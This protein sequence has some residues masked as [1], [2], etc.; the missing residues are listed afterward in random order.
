MSLLNL[1]ETRV[2]KSKV[3]RYRLNLRTE[4]L[5]EQF[6]KMSNGEG[7]SARKGN[8]FQT[9]TTQLLKKCF[10]MFSLQLLTKSL[11]PCDVPQWQEHN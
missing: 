5:R 8:L 3:L 10:L 7:L 11:Q 4:F 2:E 1:K 9:G 6:G